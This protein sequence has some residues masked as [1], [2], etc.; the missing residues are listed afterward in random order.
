MSDT[1]VDAT[2]ARIVGSFYQALLTG[3]MVQS[4]V[5]PD[6]MPTGAD[7]AEAVRRVT[8]GEVLGPY[9]QERGAAARDE[10]G[11]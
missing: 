1:E 9:G 6:A 10:D 2:A 3:L 7:L 4:L 8:E 5:R 11:A